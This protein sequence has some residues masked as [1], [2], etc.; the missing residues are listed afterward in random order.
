[1]KSKLEKE[2]DFGTIF[3]TINPKTQNKYEYEY[4]QQKNK[5]STFA[6]WMDASKKLDNAPSPKRKILKF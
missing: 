2:R 5:K 3:D 1:M 6:N 4:D